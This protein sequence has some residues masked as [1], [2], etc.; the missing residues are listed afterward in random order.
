MNNVSKTKELI[1]MLH[2]Q[3]GEI[4][5]A[6]LP[7]WGNTMTEAAETLQCYVTAIDAIYN[8]NEA[9]RASVLMHCGLWHTTH[10]AAL[11]P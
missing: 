5:A 7:G 6:G 11:D 8:H 2:K 9:A 10:S 1:E 3:A 4:A